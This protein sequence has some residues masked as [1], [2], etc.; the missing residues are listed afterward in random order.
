MGYWKLTRWCD[1]AVKKILYT[2]DR[3]AVHAELKQHLDDRMD[4]FLSKGMAK[5][6]AVAKTLEIMGSPDE[7]SVILGQIHRPYWGFA[8]S[9]SRVLAI[10]LAIFVLALLVLNTARVLFV[11]EYRQP[12]YFTYDPYQDTTSE[13]RNRLGL[14][15]Q[16]DST[17]CGGYTYDLETCAIWRDDHINSDILYARLRITNYLPWAQ[18]PVLDDNL[19]AVDNLGNQY[20]TRTAYR[21][22]ADSAFHTN[23]FEWLLDVNIYAPDF[24]G[25]KWIEIR[26][27]FNNDFVLRIDLTRGGVQ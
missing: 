18:D 23:P 12:K 27:Q 26:N 9:I 14:W 21:I 25:V 8:Y 4:S 3:E 20:T 2:P 6:E 16:L 15:E 11:E 22:S 1:I 5:E 13:R 10:A 7:L 24:T 19:V 17:S